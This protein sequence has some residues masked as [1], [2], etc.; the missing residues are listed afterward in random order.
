MICGDCL[1]VCLPDPAKLVLADPPYNLGV[2][3]GEDEYGGRYDDRMSDKEYSSTLNQWCARARLCSRWE[4]GVVA[5][6][7]DAR[8]TRVQWDRA[9][10]PD[11]NW[12]H[13]IIV[14]ETFAQY[15][16]DRNWTLDWRIL[17]LW[18]NRQPKFC[19]AAQV[20]WD[21]PGTI[22][23]ES[24]R[25]KMG[26]KRGGKLGRIP[27]SVW[28]IPRLTG[29][30]KYRHPD[31]P[32]QVHPDLWRRLMLAYTEPG[33]LVVDMFCGVGGSGLVAQELGRRWVGIERNPE[34]CRIARERL[35]LEV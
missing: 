29:N 14:H 17:M 22:R 30:S 8:N 5:F 32:C 20:A 24:D 15:Q 7:N 25:L 21:Q 35:G 3:Y 18:A 27:G 10:R 11:V 19:S 28:R 1:D 16:G 13:P 2:D 31:H 23:V 12:V 6:L 34:Y 9:L 33:D 26:D 4:D